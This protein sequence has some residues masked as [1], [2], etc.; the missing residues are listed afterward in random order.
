MIASRPRQ[1]IYPGPAR[2]VLATA[3]LA[4]PAACSKGPDPDLIGNWRCH[5]LQPTPHEIMDFDMSVQP[6]GDIALEA[7]AVGD[8]DDGEFKFAYSARGKL[9]TKG[10]KFRTAFHDIDVHSASM[11]DVPYTQSQLDDLEQEI[12]DAV[13]FLFTVESLTATDL[14]MHDRTSRTVCQRAEG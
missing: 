7:E 8:T 2:A 10:D 6:S 3:L 11:N 4:F 5:E 1:A 12:L 14:A 13:G 9:T